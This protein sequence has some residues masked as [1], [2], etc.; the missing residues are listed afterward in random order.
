M[1]ELER[2]E[3]YLDRQGLLLNAQRLRSLWDGLQIGQQWQTIGSRLQ[4]NWLV[5]RTLTG[6]GDGMPDTRLRKYGQPPRRHRQQTASDSREA[7]EAPRRRTVRRAVPAA[8]RSPYAPPP[9]PRR[10]R[11]P[12]ECLL[13]L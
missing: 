13:T 2:P 11:Q 7:L 5:P 3:D 9:S 1:P 8:R 10:R 12:T 4:A 6:S